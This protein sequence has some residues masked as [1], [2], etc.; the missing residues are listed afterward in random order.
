MNEEITK[1]CEE[2]YNCFYYIQNN[3]TG[4][5]CVGQKESCFE[6]REKRKSLEANE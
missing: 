3:D 5:E 1:V 6:H 4:E 2:C